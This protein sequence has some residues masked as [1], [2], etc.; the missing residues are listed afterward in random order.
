[1]TVISLFNISAYFLPYAALKQSENYH[2]DWKLKLHS[3]LNAY[4]IV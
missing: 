3:F 2:L 4:Q 1:L